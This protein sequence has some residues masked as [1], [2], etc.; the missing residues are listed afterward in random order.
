[1]Q[2]KVGEHIVELTPGETFVFGRGTDADLQVTDG[3][4]DV[5]VSR[6]AGRLEFDTFAW[7]VTNIG[8]RPFF[9][10]VA[11]DENELV[12]GDGAQASTLMLSD[13]PWIRIP[14]STGDAALEMS[15]PSDERP[16]Q[17][18]LEA[19][20]TSAAATVVERTVT[21]TDNELRSVVAVYAGYLSLPP[22]YRREPNSYRAAANRLRVE[23]GKVRADLRRV[24]EK[25]QRA[26]GQLSGGSRARDELIQWLSSRR[27]VRREHLQ[28]LIP[29]Q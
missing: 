11:A 28:V 12:P 19:T 2:V 27:V 4:D 16:D 21:L 29:D 22:H 8:R 25:V 18:V 10:I 1:M 14:T 15:I 20:G 3:P 5:R 7:R 6:R 13:D 17:R 24:R 9:V 26:G 23:E